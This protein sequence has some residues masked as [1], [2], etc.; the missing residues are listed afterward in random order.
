MT[1]H[2]NV[3]ALNNAIEHKQEEKYQTV[4]EENCATHKHAQLSDRQNAAAK[5]KR[6]LLLFHIY[7]SLLLKT[8]LDAVD[9]KATQVVRLV[10]SIP[11]ATCL[12][13][14]SIVKLTVTP[15][16]LGLAS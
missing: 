15:L 9:R 10:A 8:H 11:T 2:R 4:V 3:T 16:R 13:T 14:Y 6:K 1:C 7:S 12:Y 5:P